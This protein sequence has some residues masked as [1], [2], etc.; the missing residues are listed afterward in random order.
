MSNFKCDKCGCSP[1]ELWMFGGFG[2]MKD[3]DKEYCEKCFNCRLEFFGIHEQEEEEEIKP[4]E[5]EDSL[6]A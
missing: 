3:D 5:K 2:P 1:E 6:S 4:Q